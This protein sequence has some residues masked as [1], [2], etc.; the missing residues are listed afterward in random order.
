MAGGEK[1]GGTK[2][3]ACDSV[4]AVMRV[5]TTEKQSVR[6]EHTA[7]SRIHTQNSKGVMGWQGPQA[8]VTDTHISTAHSMVNNEEGD[9]HHL[10]QALSEQNKTSQKY[11]T[12]TIFVKYS[13][14][15]NKYT[16]WLR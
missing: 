11:I 5:P 10:Y 15:A 7:H 1:E 2:A 9:H 14:R 16:A 4:G 13:F 3:D 6:P 8:S 12:R